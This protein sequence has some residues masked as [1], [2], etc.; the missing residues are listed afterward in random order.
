[1]EF[2]AEAANFG[3]LTDEHGEDDWH[4]GSSTLASRAWP[5]YGRCLARSTRLSQF[6]CL[7]VGSRPRGGA[8]GPGGSVDLSE[9]DKHVLMALYSGVLS[10]EISDFLGMDVGKVETILERLFEVDVLEEVRKRGEVWMKTRGRNI[11]SEAINEGW[12]PATV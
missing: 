11:A 2:L 10:F 8:E 5:A 7:S 4:F 6:S 9:K 12:R 1:M 3:L